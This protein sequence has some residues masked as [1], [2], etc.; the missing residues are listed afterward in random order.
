M[1]TS[2]PE[3]PVRPE[4]PFGRLHWKS[5]ST[6]DGSLAPD[7]RFPC[8]APEANLLGSRTAEGMHLVTLDIDFPARLLPSS[9]PGHFHLLLDKPM[10][11]RQYRRFLRA[12]YLG[13][14]IGWNTYWR[15]LDNAASFVRANGIVKPEHLRVP[16][17]WS[18]PSTSQAR[19]ELR[20]VKWR[21][22]R[23]RFRWW[24]RETVRGIS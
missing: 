19:R 1:D 10:T 9:T 3:L 12:A 7:G 15:S 13:G 2:Q 5:P 23:A 24:W 14:L 11:W 6:L 21:V 17:R 16:T 8:P 4:D 20:A 18:P 22:L